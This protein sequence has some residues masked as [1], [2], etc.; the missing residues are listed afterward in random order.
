MNK[1]NKK[2]LILIL[3]ILFLIAIFRFS[4]DNVDFSTF[5]PD[6]NGGMQIKDIVS[7]NHTVI[8]LPDREDISLLEPD[9]SAFVLLGPHDNFSEKDIESIK[10]FTDAGG[11]LI[12]A[13][14]FGTG[15]QLLN[16]LSGSVSF[17]NQLL[18]DDVNFWK[19]STFPIVTTDIENVSNITL[20][21]GTSL[22]IRDNSMNI[23]ANSS[24]FSWL[25]SNVS[26]GGKR[27][28]YP[29]IAE[30][31][32]G[33]GEILVVSDP[34][35]FINSML[36]MQDNMLLLGKLVGNRTIVAF[37][38]TGRMPPVAF[39]N[40]LIK[41]NTSFQYLFTA[42]VIAFALIYI[43]REQ[44]KGFGMKKTGIVKDK[45]ILDEEHIVSDILK[46]HKWDKRN[47]MIFRN[48]LKENK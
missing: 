24:Y 40:Y 35:I 39:F 45:L 27:S 17:S 19:N 41:T 47:F 33:K 22:V 6:W 36:P 5:N 18:Q 14:D 2:I 9:K 21:Y 20:N 32:M 3:S 8:S 43:K 30:L 44:I 42:I 4:E 23:L 7:E 1:A 46:R 13:D 12:L 11:L 10:K 34:S 38:E 48:K 28:S 25:S 16:R 29:V 15:N 31:A 37:D 26:E